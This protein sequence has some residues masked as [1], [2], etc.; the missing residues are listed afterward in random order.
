[1]KTLELTK[2]TAS[3]AEYAQDVK[4]EPVI[5]TSGGKPVAALVAVENADLE[6]ATLSTH[7]QFLALI[8]RSRSRQK[9]EGGISSQE[10]HRR[11]GLK[12]RGGRRQPRP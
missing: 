9:A 3:L 10:M 2:A 11:L 4:K 7:P 6:T 5:L 8:E 1:M 12:R